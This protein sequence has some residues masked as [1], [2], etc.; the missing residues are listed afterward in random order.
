MARAAWRAGRNAAASMAAMAAKSAAMAADTVQDLRDAPAA[1]EAR[2]RDSGGAPSARRCV[3]VYIHVC[4]YMC[5]CIQCVEMRQLRR[6]GVT[7]GGL[8]LSSRR[9]RAEVY[10]HRKHIYIYIYIY[11]YCG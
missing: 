1:A 4:M 3:C 2:G 5:M 10:V 8:Q 9:L 7:A 11:I 6:A